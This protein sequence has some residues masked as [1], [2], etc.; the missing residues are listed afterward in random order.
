MSSR[1]CI[2]ALAVAL[3]L[4]LPLASGAQQPPPKP[5]GSATFRIFVR[6]TA[7]GTEDIAVVRD[8]SGWTIVSSGRL[9]APFD[10]VTR[11]L[12]LR[13][14]ADWRP[15]EMTLDATVRGQPQTMRTTISGG[16]ARSEITVAGQPALVPFTVNADLLLPNPFFGP[17]EALTARLR[18]A[19]ADTTLTALAPP[20]TVL[21]LRVGDSSHERIQSA[22]RTIE[23]TYTRL[24][25]TPA[26]AAGDAA[27]VETH[28]WADGNG[29]LLR[30]SVPSQGLEVVREDL[31]SV[32]TRQVP[33]SRSNDEP[34]TVPSNGFTLAGTLSKPASTAAGRLPAVLLA[35]GNGITDRD[36]VVAGI[37]IFGEL[38]G[39]IADGGFIVLRYDP[40]GVGQSGGR[41]EAAALTDYA[42][43]ARAAVKFLAGRKDVDPKHVAVVGYG[44]AGP[45]AMLAAKDKRISA[46][47]L[48]ATLGET[49]ADM[50]LDQVRH[51]LDRTNRSAADK[52]T[53]IDLQKRIQEAVLS[54]TGWDQLAPYRKQA[55]TPWFQSFLAFDPAKVVPD[56]RQP[57]LIVQG[58]LDTQT[59]PDNADRLQ[60]LAAKRKGAPAPQLVKIPDVNHLLATARTGESDEYESLPDKHVSPEVPRAIVAWLK[61]LPGN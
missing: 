19:A 43:D 15:L 11:R 51:A 16:E 45:V 7:V 10:I 33:I 36:E 60:A 39:A 30:V 50:N 12:Q 5:A 47:V 59:A 61:A 20:Q 48:I 28:V 34:I 24:M 49:G 22:A 56:L 3:A 21:T 1:H 29:R 26:S 55:D 2:R 38:A 4:A 18:T 23:A 54:G 17:F 37:P 42:D 35:S 41:P 6:G 13:Y 53:T 57:L 40:R 44:E 14:D 27:P 8:A 52:Q 31:A 46:V 32:S 25:L 9:N 58:G